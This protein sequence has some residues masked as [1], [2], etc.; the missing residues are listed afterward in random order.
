[1]RSATLMTE[2]SAFPLIELSG[3]VIT[4]GRSYGEQARERIHASIDMYS[5]QI[6]KHGLSAAL[7]AENSRSFTDQIKRFAPHLLTE[8]EHIAEGANVGFL[9]ILLLNARTEFLQLAHRFGLS[10]GATN[11]ADGCT[12]VVVL[13]EAAREGSL[14]QGQTWDWRAECIDTAVVLRIARDDG[15]D[16]M[17]FTEAGG[18]A[19]NGFNSAGVVITAN[20]LESDRDY[21]TLGVPL[22]VIRR[23]ALESAHYADAIRMVATTAKSGS[24]NMIVSSAEGFS[25]DFECAPDETFPIYPENGLLVHANHWLSPVALTKLKETGLPSVPDSLYRDIRVREHLRAHIGSITLDHI[26]EAFNDRFGEPYSVCRPPI[27]S[28]GGR[29]SA[30]VAIVLIEPAHGR[31]EV[32]PMPA[33]NTRS[34]SYYLQMDEHRRPI[35]A[36]A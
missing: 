30:T 33:L 8:M 21:R 28:E 4:R 29:L 32:T 15:P 7:M 31:M 5:S 13:P 11:E 12:G 16:M 3:E 18:L 19:R 1:M 14:L 25:V 24:N 35:A 27:Q 34:E 20:Y 2:Y 6:S 10:K 22:P 23:K 26:R 9:Q 36:S 17:I